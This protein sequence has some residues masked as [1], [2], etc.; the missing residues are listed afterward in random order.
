[1]YSYLIWRAWYNGLSTMM[2]KP[3]RAVELR[4]PMIQFLIEYNTL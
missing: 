3:I 2:A 1:M 4:Y